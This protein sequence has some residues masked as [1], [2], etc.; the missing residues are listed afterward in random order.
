MEVRCF[1]TGGERFLQVRNG[2]V[3]LALGQQRGPKIGLRPSVAG[4]QLE[5]L[6]EMHDGFVD[7]A[8]PRQR[9]AKVV[10]GVGIRGV[11]LDGFPVVG[12]GLV[13]TVCRG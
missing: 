12:D 3:E 1:R 7:L 11:D 2:L 4:A 6:P 5:C 10:V 13:E 8:L 9:G